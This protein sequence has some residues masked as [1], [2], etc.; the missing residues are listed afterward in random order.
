MITGIIIGGSFIALGQIAVVLIGWR[1]AKI[2]PQFEVEFA[3]LDPLAAKLAER[4]Q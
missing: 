2:R 4:A 1:F 3:D